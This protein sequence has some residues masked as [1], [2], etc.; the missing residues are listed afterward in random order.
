MVLYLVYGTKNNTKRYINRTR[1]LGRNHLSQHIFLQHL[2]MVCSRC[3]LHINRTRIHLLLSALVQIQ[4]DHRISAVDTGS[5]RNLRRR[6]GTAR[7]G[8]YDMGDNEPV[9]INC[10]QLPHRHPPPHQVDV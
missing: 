1:R 10:I 7:S 8:T 9:T 2:R 3:T 6:S 5:G 4:L